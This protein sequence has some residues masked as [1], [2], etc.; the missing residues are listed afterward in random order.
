M[1][2]PMILSAY[3]QRTQTWSHL[4]VDVST[5]S[6]ALIDPVMGYDPKNGRIDYL[7]A[8]QWLDQI[9]TQSWT[10]EW[11][12]ETH[13]HAD[14]LS[15]AHYIQKK[16]GGRIGIGEKVKEVQAKFIPLFDLEELRP[17]GSGFD[18][19]FKDGEVFKLGTLEGHILFTPGHTPADITFVI[20]RAA[21]I[22]DTLF[23][24]DY[25]TA[26]CDFPGGDAG[27]LYDSIHKILQLP[28]DTDLYL[29][30]DYPVGDRKPVAKTS[31]AEQRANIHLIKATNK[32]DFIAMRKERD[33]TLA[34]PVLLLPSLQVNIRA[35]DLPP[36]SNN[37]TR[38][39][40]I[41]LNKL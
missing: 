3:D 15:A 19:L 21:F 31:I 40:K 18:H 4:A 37:G 12:L 29:C 16:V 25:G 32:T 41:P 26:R 28:E 24:P 11:I 14:H 33:A 8:D 38:Y 17:N 6:A 36:P 27:A 30:H 39:L 5:G 23:A 7:L 9:K 10:L 34:A 2:Q 22:G 1:S 35:G 13:V 20:G